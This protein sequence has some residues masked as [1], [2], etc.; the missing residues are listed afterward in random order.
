[1]G[2]GIIERVGFWFV[3]L[4]AFV[5]ILSPAQAG[6]GY[7]LL[8]VDGHDVKWGDPLPD[9]G[10]TI[11]YTVASGQTAATGIENCRVTTGVDGL[12][13]RSHITLKQFDDAL[14]AALGM[15]EK[16]AN[17]RFVRVPGGK[18]VDVVVAAEAVPDG[19]AYSDVTPV[20]SETGSFDQIKKG[21]VCLNPSLQWT[22]DNAGPTGGKR[23]YKLRYV[24]AHE[25]GHVL[26]LD[27][28]SPTG[29]LMS[30]EYNDA[31][32]TLQP[33]DIAGLV[34]LYGKPQPAEPTIALNRAAAAD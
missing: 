20:M 30:F 22:A 23:T 13:V 10:A 19:I 34:A 14:A 24:L 3:A 27:H 12:L 33:G 4:A 21:V 32:D 17:V 11:T 25:F 16:A 26:G 7:R 1:V 6:D 15:W 18:T 2:F 5:S 8:R 31:L 9:K 28:P 29:E